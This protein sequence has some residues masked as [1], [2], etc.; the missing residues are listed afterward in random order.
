MRDSFPLTESRN[1]RPVS[2]T[3]VRDDP[4]ANWDLI[5]PCVRAWYAKR[6]VVFG[7][8]STGK[9]T[10]TRNLATHF[11]T[12][13]VPEYARAYLEEQNGELSLEDI[14]HI[15]RGQ[16]SSEESLA[17]HCNRLLFTD[18]DVLATTVWSHFLYGECPKWIEEAAD[19]RPADL[20][21]LTDVDVPWVEDV[22]RY[23]PEN[24]SDFLEKCEVTLKAHG[25]NYVRLS[26]SWD[27]RF[28][29]AVEAVSALC[30]VPTSP[31]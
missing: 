27:Q 26:G 11:D 1:I 28:S 12:I 17:P 9:S 15:A 3:S 31:S 5:P 20:Y 8:E 2:G 4:F 30:S 19:E 21:L 18:T 25:R 22:I 7:P 13:A 16:I 24:R 29:N 23:L 6:V 14:P 10:L